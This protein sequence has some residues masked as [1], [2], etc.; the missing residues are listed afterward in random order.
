MKKILKSTLVVAVLAVSA[1]IGYVSYNQYQN[2]QLAFAN[3][4]LEE[5][6]DALA[7]VNGSVPNGKV[8]IY[9]STTKCHKLVKDPKQSQGEGD[10]KVYWHY[11]D[12]RNAAN[13]RLIDVE[14][15]KGEL[16]CQTWMLKNCS[17]YGGTVH[18]IPATLLGW[19]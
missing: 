15:Y 19:Y 6:I 14:K 7:D 18:E 16:L 11:D 12:T 2:Q 8:E 10:E 9:T 4:L 3:P 17:H 5:N 13:C 1:A